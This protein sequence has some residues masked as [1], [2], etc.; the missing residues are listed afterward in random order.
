[1]GWKRAGMVLFWLLVEMG[2]FVMH[3]RQM[4]NIKERAERASQE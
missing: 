4:L 3:H 2:D 1:M